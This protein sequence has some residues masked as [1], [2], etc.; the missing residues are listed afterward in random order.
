MVKPTNMHLESQEHLI[1][2]QMLIYS[3]TME[4]GVESEIYLSLNS[5]SS[6]KWQDPAILSVC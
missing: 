3:I 2:K 6:S 1:N 4:L 5:L